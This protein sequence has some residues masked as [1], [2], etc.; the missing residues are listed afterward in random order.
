MVNIGFA[1]RG[2]D[3][4][5]AAILQAESDATTHDQIVDGFNRRGSQLVKSLI[6]SF[7]FLGHWS[8]VEASEASKSVSVGDLVAQF[9]I[10]QVLNPPEDIGAEGLLGC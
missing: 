1:D 7:V 4:E 3:T 5:F 10:A 8:A 6:E 9:A 2:V